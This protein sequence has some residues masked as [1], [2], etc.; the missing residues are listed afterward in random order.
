MPTQASGAFKKFI[1]WSGH[2]TTLLPILVALKVFD[3]QNW[4]GYASRIILEVRARTHVRMHATH[5]HT[6][7]HTH[8]ELSIHC[9]CTFV[10]SIHAFLF[11][12]H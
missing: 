6:L 10:L 5:M 9:I 1:L 3:K 2:D 7:T 4:P 12:F 11:F 8:M